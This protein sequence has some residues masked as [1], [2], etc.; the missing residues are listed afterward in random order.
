MVINLNSV[1]IEGKVKDIAP[2]EGNKF[3]FNLSSNKIVKFEGEKT[4]E[5][6]CIPV[7]AFGKLADSAFSNIKIGTKLRVVGYMRM[8]KETDKGGNQIQGIVIH[9]EHIEYKSNQEI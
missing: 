3:Y 2:F 9:A 4:V 1:L 7:E 6:I 8:N 5:E